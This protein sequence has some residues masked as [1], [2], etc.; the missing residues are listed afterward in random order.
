MPYTLTLSL[1]NNYTTIHGDV[2]Q[3]DRSRTTRNV[4]SFNT[5]EST[6]TSSQP[7]PL[8]PALFEP[9][10]SPGDRPSPSNNIPHDPH[11]APGRRRTS[12]SPSNNVEHAYPPAPQFTH[13]NT[14][15][16]SLD[17]VSAMRNATT[18]PVAKHLY[19]YVFQKVTGWSHSLL[20]YICMKYL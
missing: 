8:H 14:S 6:H 17:D 19:Q 10:T 9:L 12:T 16:D 11:Q 20:G 18:T 13:S 1:F 3:S 7:P 15:S 5:I 4:D 2:Y